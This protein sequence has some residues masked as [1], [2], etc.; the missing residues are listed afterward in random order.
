MDPYEEFT[1]RQALAVV[2]DRLEA[3]L[4][5]ADRWDDEPPASDLLD[6]GRP[7][8]FDTLTFEQWVQWHMIPR[9]RRI[10][11][12]YETLPESSAILPYAEE[13]AQGPGAER[14]E[15]LHLIRR[16]DALITG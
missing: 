3:A 8:C 14:R 2:I 16:F 1:R 5:G 9:M 15:L 10:L 6:T 13:R 11:D 4:R 7:F 12:N